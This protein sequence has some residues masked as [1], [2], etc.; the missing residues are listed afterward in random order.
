MGSVDDS[1][2]DLPEPDRSCL[3]HVID[4]ARAVVPEAQ[5]G[6]SYGMPALKFEGKPLVGVVRAA[7]QLSVFPFSPAV[8]DA[9]ASRFE[10]YSLSKGTIRFT[11]AHPLP[12]D[13][14]ED[15]VRLRRAEILK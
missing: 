7:K 14:L 6:M 2:A 3:Q 13:V 4:I 1:L 5:Q 12:D 10:G 11:A 15:I 8:I 9:V